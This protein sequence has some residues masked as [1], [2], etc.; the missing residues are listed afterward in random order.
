[1]DAYN[2]SEESVLW[3]SSYLSERQQYVQVESKVSQCITLNDYG[4]PQGSVLGPLIFLIFNNDFPASSTC[5]NSVLFADDNTDNAS[6]KCPDELLRKIQSEGNLSCAWVDDNNMSCAGDKTKLIVMGTRQLR[7]SKLNETGNQL[8]INICG[9]EVRET[10]SDKLLGLVVNNSLQ[11]W[12]SVR[13]KSL[14]PLSVPW[15]V[16]NFWCENFVSKNFSGSF[17]FGV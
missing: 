5:G 14:I 15:V 3:F 12:F 4:V 10:E 1:M 17:F 6:A 11:L 16:K 13:E 2:F 8:K 7:L 9:N